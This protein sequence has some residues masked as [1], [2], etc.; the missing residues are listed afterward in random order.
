MPLRPDCQRLQ[1]GTAVAGPAAP[2]GL[3]LPGGG[4]CSGLV[5]AAA[6]PHALAVKPARNAAASAAAL[7]LDSGSMDMFGCSML[8]SSLVPGVHQ[9]GSQHNQVLTGQ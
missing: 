3:W 5:Q 4:S 9:M 7:A 1:P 2:P 8:L 6:A